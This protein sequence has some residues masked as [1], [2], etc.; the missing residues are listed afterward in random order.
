M[1]HRRERPHAGALAL[2]VL[3]AASLTLG[4]TSATPPAPPSGVPDLL[5]VSRKPLAR[6]PRAGIPG[7]GPLQRAAAP[8]GRLMVRR[9]NGHVAPFL[10]GA[11]LFDVSDPAVSYDG[12]LVAFAAV[13]HR[14]S[15]WRIWVADVDGHDA[16]AIT[17]TDR[18]IDLRALGLAAA[19]LG[20]YDDLDPC[21]LPDGR[22]CFASTRFPERSESGALATNL[23]VIDADG[24]RLARITSEHNGGEEPSVDPV[25][26]RIV[27][28]RWWT[29]RFYASDSEA[30]GFTTELGRALPGERVSLW[31]AITVQPDGDG[32]RLAGGYPRVRASTMAYQP[33]RL[34]DGTLVGVTAETLSL[35]PRPGRVHLVVY[36][37]GFAEPVAFPAAPAQ[38]CAPAAL[39]DGRLAVAYD[40]SGRGDFGLAVVGTDGRGLQPLVDMKS[41][42]ELDPVV[43]APRAPAPVLGEGLGGLHRELPPY[44][45]ADVEQSG[46]TVRFDCLNVFA[47]GPVDFPTP[48]APPIARDVKIRFFAALARPDDAGGD[49]I[50]HVRDADVTRSGAVHEDAIPADVPMFEQ[51]IDAHGHVLMSVGGPAHVPGFNAGR[52]GSGTKCVGCHTGHSAIAVAESYAQGKRFNAAP[53]ATVTTTSEADGAHARAVVDRRTLGRPSEVAWIARGQEGEAVT[54]TWPFP[55]ALDSLVVYGIRPDG[56]AGTNLTVEACDVTLR[57]HGKAPARLRIAGGVW[58]TGAALA[59]R[60]RLVD[61]V[62]LRPSGS[63]GTVGGRARTGLAEVE[64]R[65]RIPEQ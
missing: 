43:L 42:L 40:A 26:G 9:A 63:R 62:E 17:R 4:L 60:G 31:H 12:R 34:E 65:A 19:A 57:L 28:A 52:P 50:V 58:P 55:L 7:L 32:L 6:D 33:L 59:C 53:S 20:R 35:V 37:G 61:A 1:T 41:T 22:I 54:L 45:S 49:T 30:A 64:A 10:T 18:A 14:D 36:P 46:T 48:D 11:H 39:P 16:H 25:T 23:F 21:W 51:L 44:A 8:G 29:S 2:A 13:T 5:F 47:N 15:A 3:A 27:Y 56:A 38:M 24:K